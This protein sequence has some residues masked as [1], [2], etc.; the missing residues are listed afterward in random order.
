MSIPF[1]LMQRINSML[2]KP[3]NNCPGAVAGEWDYCGAPDCMP[4]YWQN[5]WSNIKFW[6]RVG[7]HG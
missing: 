2:R 1:N 4:Y 3:C 6:W 7:R 5:W